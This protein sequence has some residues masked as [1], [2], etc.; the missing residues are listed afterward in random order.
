MIEK[1]ILMG[2]MMTQ[3]IW[4]P[5]YSVGVKVLD[6]QHKIMFSLANEL[7]SAEKEHNVKISRYHLTKLIEY[8]ELHFTTEE[9]LLEMFD[10]RELKAHQQKH[11]KLINQL[12]Q[13]HQKMVYEGIDIFPELTKLTE[14][15]ITEHLLGADRDYVR[16]FKEND[17]T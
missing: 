1:Q 4:K 17:C 9:D 11:A 12:F 14:N 7:F 15:W 6:I 2:V 5:E 8:A 16:F 3:F 10:Y 13:L